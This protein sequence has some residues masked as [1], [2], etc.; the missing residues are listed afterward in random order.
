MALYTPVEWE[1]NQEIQLSFVLPYSR[2]QFGVRAFV[3]NRDGFRYGIEFANL[4][5]QEIA[6]IERVTRILAMTA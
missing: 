3:R 2:V 1:L 6:E 5:E 4:G